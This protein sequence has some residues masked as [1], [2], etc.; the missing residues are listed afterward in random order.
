MKPLP[1]LAAGLFLLVVA[2]K[3]VSAQDLMDLFDEGPTTEYAYGTFKTTR[4][5]LNHSVQSPAPGELVFIISHHFGRINEGLYT[6]FGLDVATIRLGLEYG[7]TDRLSLGI[8]RGTYRKMFD[9]HVKFKLL[10]QSSGAHQMP[11]TLTYFGSM[12][13]NS[14]KWQYPERDNYFTSRLS[15]VHQLL[16]ARKFNNLI[17]L[18]LTP[19]V[20]HRNLVKATNDQNTVFALG[21]GG[22]VKL[23]QRITLNA[24]YFHLLPGKT[25]DDFD[26]SL[27]VGF[28][29]ETG[30]HVFQ[31]F[32]TNSNPITEH[33]FITETVGR[34]DKGD[35][36]FG[37]NITRAFTL[38]ANTR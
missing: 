32:F 26:N 7:L 12:G 3:P 4:L 5:V 10:R 30:G 31:L 19:S 13:I 36:Y 28:D 25:A 16:I 8:G 20:V 1:R 34:W 18:Q 9:G 14:L 27:S 35:V 22:R 2:I 23:T 37:F 6:L 21:A 29:I 15:Y 33:G 17:S 11:V 24:E 38:K